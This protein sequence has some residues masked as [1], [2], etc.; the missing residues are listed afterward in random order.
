MRI[1]NWLTFLLK[2]VAET[3]IGN[4][5]AKNTLKIVVELSLTFR[6]TE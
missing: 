2:F 4:L 6:W 3:Q 1:R 5:V